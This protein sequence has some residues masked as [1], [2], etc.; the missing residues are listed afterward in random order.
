MSTSAQSEHWRPVA[1]DGVPH[2]L[3]VVTGMLTE[4]AQTVGIEGFSGA[5]PFGGST[6]AIVDA[7]G[8]DDG[9]SVAELIDSATGLVRDIELGDIGRPWFVGIL[10]SVGLFGGKSPET[11]FPVLVGYDL[12]TDEV[13]WLTDLTPDDFYPDEPSE[14]IPNVRS[15]EASPTEQYAIVRI[16]IA[17][18][19]DFDYLIAADGAFLSDLG[20]G[21]GR[22]FVGLNDLWDSS[23]GWFDEGLLLYRTETGSAYLLDLFTLERETVL[24]PDIRGFG[25][26]WA[27]GDGVHVIGTRE[28][29]MAL[30]NLDDGTVVPL[31][32]APCDIEIGRIGWTGNDG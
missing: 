20:G 21:A 22:L 30:I 9:R 13:V 15:A 2:R 19:P 17:T 18:S 5:A 1:L 3:D 10:G 16:A 12:V 26:L 23:A 28:A 27:S 25:R 11:R 31:V 32:S 24:L 7:R 8:E 4:L 14:T 6:L 29:G